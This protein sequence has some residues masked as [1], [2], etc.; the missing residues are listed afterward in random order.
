M[1]ALA[2]IVTVSLLFGALYLA[3]VI[4]LHWSFAPI[5]QIARLLRDMLPLKRL[6]K[7][8]ANV[9]AATIVTK[10]E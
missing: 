10:N 5:H 8:K 1:E 4:V 7:P 9:S 6:S 3:A 2:R